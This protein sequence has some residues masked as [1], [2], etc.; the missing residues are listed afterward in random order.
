MSVEEPKGW[1][2]ELHEELHR[3]HAQESKVAPKKP[4]SKSQPKE[5]SSKSSEP[6]SSSKEPPDHKK[7]E[8][9][10]QR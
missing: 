2:P 7:K 5:I 8:G 1:Q 3:L 10:G 6:K 9:G 4:R